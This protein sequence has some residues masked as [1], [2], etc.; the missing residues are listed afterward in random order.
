[1]LG[2]G[3]GFIR[4]AEGGPDIFFHESGLANASLDTLKEGAVCTYD[5]EQGARGPRAIRIYVA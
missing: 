4:P 5:V 1:M 3:Y 2:R